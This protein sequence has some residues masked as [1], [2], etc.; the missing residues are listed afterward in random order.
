MGPLCPHQQHRH[1]RP[2][3]R[4]LLRKR[5]P[6]RQPLAVGCPP[7]R[8]PARRRRR[9]GRR[10]GLH[11]RVRPLRLSRHVPQ[12]EGEEP[13]GRLRLLPEGGGRLRGIQLPAGRHPQPGGLHR[14]DGRC[15]QLPLAHSRHRPGGPPAGGPRPRL[16]AA[17][18]PASWRTSTSSGSW[19][20]RPTRRRTSAG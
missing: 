10:E 18:R 5:L 3:V 14:P 12:R 20:A 2:A 1:L 19:H 4:Q 17:R 15:P 6:S 16:A 9:G 7:A 13:A 11:H 8:L